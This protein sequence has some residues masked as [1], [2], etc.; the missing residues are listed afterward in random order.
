MN[1]DSILDEMDLPLTNPNEE[2]ETISKNLLL[3]HFDTSK[4]EIR[5]E[6]FRD[7]GN[8]TLLYN[9]KTLKLFLFFFAI[10]YTSFAG[11][12][13]YNNWQVCC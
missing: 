12:E 7:K 6:D 2:L 1:D 11:D 13:N 10:H 5:S 9:M 3:P 4:F 8:N